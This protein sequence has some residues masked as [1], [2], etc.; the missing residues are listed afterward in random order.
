MGREPVLLFG[1]NPFS[2]DFFALQTLTEARTKRGLKPRKPEDVLIF[3]Y[4]QELGL[5]DAK[6]AKLIDLP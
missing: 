3:R 5:G 1:E 6:D 4:A 2:V